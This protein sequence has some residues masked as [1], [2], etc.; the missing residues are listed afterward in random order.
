MRTFREKVFRLR[1]G[2]WT[3]LFLLILILAQPTRQSLLLGLPFVLLGQLWR[4][5]AVGC[6]G[7]Y[8]GET[9]GAERLATWG[10]YAFMRNPLYF[11][12]GL[13]GLGWGLMAGPWAALLFLVSFFVLYGL[14]IVPHE[15]S[16]LL[17]KFGDAYRDYR[18]RTG[19]FL[20]R[21][22]PSGRIAG[23]FAA[24]I[25]W[26]SERHTLLSTLAGTLLIAAK[27]FLSFPF[28]FFP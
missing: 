16:F 11:G 28:P 19:A 9:V 7:R 23:P 1:G 17:S 8:R 4:F 21:A 26:T 12:N 5:W 2:I 6:I 27:G 25:L 22:W 14:L 18:T 10:P 3:L 20:P 24:G 15:E 13:I